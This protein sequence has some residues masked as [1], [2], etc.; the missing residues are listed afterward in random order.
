LL[1]EHDMD[2]VL[3]LSQEVYVLDFGELIAHGTPTSI[4]RDGSVR[5]AYLG[6]ELPSGRPAR[7]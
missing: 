3:G 4:R 1:V 5:A 7:R 2:F 6:E